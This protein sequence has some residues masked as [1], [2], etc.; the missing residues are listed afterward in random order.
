MITFK[1]RK[2]TTLII[3]HD[4]HTRP[5]KVGDVER[6]ATLAHEQGLKMGLLAIGYHAI[7]ERDGTVVVCR[8]HEKIGTH[9]PGLNLESVA[10]CLVGGR[11]EPEG[12]GVDNFTPEQRRSLLRLLH[13]LTIIYPKAKV[14]GH[15]EVQKFRRDHPDCPPIDMDLLRDDLKLFAQ[16]IV[17]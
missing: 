10:I 3:I 2:T 11:E 16:G 9:T 12:D 13:E 17:L 14:R 8:P 6:W 5:G 4:S 7:L 1:G 15:S